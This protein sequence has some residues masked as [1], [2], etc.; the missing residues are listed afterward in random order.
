MFVQII[1]GSVADGAALR[2]EW[3]AWVGELSPQA[4][5]WLG[6]TAGVTPDGR[7]IAA[8]RFASREDAAR[9]SDRPEQDAWWQR[10]A[11]CF[12]EP[13][14]F[15]E[16]EDVVGHDDGSDGAGFV[17]MMRGNVR[18]RAKLQRVEA[19]VGDLWATHRPD[20]IGGYRLW[21]GDEEVLMVDYFTSE[22]EARAGEGRPMPA[23]LESGFAQFQQ[24]IVE[25]RWY[26]LP[27]PWL[28]S[29]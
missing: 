22:A 6:S 11:A 10:T 13:P 29:P 12:S 7:F 14:R 20:F 19:D 1:E 5:G 24:L 28:H 9:N 3:D 21:L 27:D 15:A 16:S 8:V 4:P 2:A 23:E 18:D 26:D 17:Q 25:P